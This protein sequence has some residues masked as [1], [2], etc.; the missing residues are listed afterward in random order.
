MNKPNK[1]KRRS[2]NFKKTRRNYLAGGL[3]LIA[4]FWSV[5]YLP[6]LRTSPPWYGDEI[7]T[8]DIGKSL[9]RG[10]MANRALPCTFVSVNYN[11][12]PAFAFVVGLGSWLTGGDIVGGRLVSILIGLVTAW[13]GFIFLG[14]RFGLSCGLFFSFVLLGYSQSIIH[15]R[16]IYP[17]NLV[18]LGL[19]ASTCLLMRPAS[20]FKDI[21]AGLFLS[22]GAG[23]HLLAIHSVIAS[24]IVR[25]F[26]PRCWLSIAL[27]PFIVLSGTLVIL[28]LTWQGWVFEDLINLKKTYQAYSKEN[29]AGIKW[30]QNI[31]AFF[32]QDGFHLAAITGIIISLR[33]RAY[34]L[35][36]CALFMILML[37]R[38][39]QNLPLF[40]YQAMVVLPLF[41]AAIAIGSNF[42]S[43]RI[44]KC[45]FGKRFKRTRRTFLPLLGIGFAFT[46]IPSVLSSSLPVRIRPWVVSETRDYETAAS[47]LNTQTETTDLV[48][49]Y[50][51][52]G[53]LL[54][55]RNADVLM[56]TAWAGLPAGD[57]YDPP[58]AR[59]RFL[60]SLDLKQA[61]YFVI[62][63]LD[64]RWAYGQGVVYGF[65]KDSEVFSWP[66]VFQA[67]SIRIL[68]NPALSGSGFIKK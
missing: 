18:G 37:T 58:P 3:I 40:Y 46:S 68:K 15:Y 13:V 34:A 8:L 63:E 53:W 57:N 41:A 27:P 45:L 50:W 19:L 9:V 61:K 14:K 56:A 4:L 10:E 60:Y 2:S 38:N 21:K 12:Q 54:K 31:M 16:W 25:L 7:L 39:R 49:A 11:Y 59:N 26:R 51:N 28:S 42:V 43:I 24:I 47:W 64:E 36:I 65:L 52:L 5:L 33:T 62:T 67:G 66:L 20:T 22:L 1:P 32:L 17:H 23:A 55:C 6:N 48:I 35:T 29:G 44:F 30:L